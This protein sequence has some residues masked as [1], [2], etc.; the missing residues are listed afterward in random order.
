MT[1]FDP[2]ADVSRRCQYEVV[3]TLK[4]EPCAPSFLF[5][6]AVAVAFVGAGLLAAYGLSARSYAAATQI[7]LLLVPAVLFPSAL[8]LFAN[9]P[10][11]F[12]I[13]V[14]AVLFGVSTQT[15][16]DLRGPDSPGMF[17]PWMGYCTGAG[18]LVAE[19]IMLLWRL[20]R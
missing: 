3:K 1:A 20:F 9:R 14:I 8:L 15:F 12:F 17:I 5:R 13:F 4:R 18:A 2:V 19:F 11:R 6:V 7:L 10:F 16:M